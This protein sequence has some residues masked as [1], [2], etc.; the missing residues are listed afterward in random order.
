MTRPRTQCHETRGGDKAE[1]VKTEETQNIEFLGGRLG[2]S[3]IQPSSTLRTL[4]GNT[5]PRPVGPLRAARKVRCNSNDHN[6]R[7]PKNAGPKKNPQVE[8]ED[9]IYGIIGSDHSFIL[10]GRDPLRVLHKGSITN[11]RFRTTTLTPRGETWACPS[12]GSSGSRCR[13][14]KNERE[15]SGGVVTAQMCRCAVQLWL[16]R[17]YILLSK[18]HR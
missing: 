8:K 15:R 2:G 13:D 1:R 17:Y 9:G 12:H 7:T 18:P 4:A 6:L 3:E 16:P 5:M 10:I 14:R 11:S